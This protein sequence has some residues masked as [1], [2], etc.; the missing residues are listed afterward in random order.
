MRRPSILSPS[1]V[2][3]I[4]EPGRFG[5]GRGSAGLSLLVKKTA[6]GRISR[7]WSQR[8]RIN[9]K[10]TN[11]GLGSYPEITLAHARKL[12]VENK[13][14][15]AEGRDPFDSGRVPFFR[16][17]LERVIEIQRGGWRGNTKTEASW[18]ST[19][20][21]YV[22]PKLG[23]RLVDHI[24]SADV[25]GVLLPI[26]TSKPETARRVRRR[27]AAVMKWSQARGHRGENPV[28]AIGAAL[29]KQNGGK[30]H[31]RALPHAEVAGAIA[32]VRTSGAWI[33]TKLALEF[34][35]LTAARSGEVRAAAWSEIDP[36]RREW[37][38]P[39]GKTK[40]GRPFRVPLSGPAM[41]V[42]AKAEKIRDGSGLVFPSVRGLELSDNTLSKLFRD[43]GIQAVP[44]GFRSSFRSWASDSG[45]SRD[46]AEAA[47]S[48]AV[49]DQTERAYARSDMFERRRR[50]MNDWA[51]YLTERQAKVIRLRA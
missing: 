45:Q 27:I 14:A 29:P 26:W 4:R 8:I 9:G 28:E 34:L 42:L 22:L 15:V 12:A 32:K 41:T 16:D 24:S 50:V 51:A 2:E 6:N 18:R 46:L 49:G 43:N 5:D 39:G 25:M 10:L 36:E 23:R 44:H 13:R 1:F 7:S 19:M 3:R 17:A 35:I 47:L 30:A 11:R 48:H 20:A 40:S 21:A 38:I 33:G 37:N 31:M